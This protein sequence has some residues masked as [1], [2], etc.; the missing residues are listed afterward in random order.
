MYISSNP[1]DNFKFGWRW[2]DSVVILV[3]LSRATNAN[4]GSI[5]GRMRL[6]QKPHYDSVGGPIKA[7]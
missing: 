2:P 1:T 7:S 6:A 4:I 3:P 5:P